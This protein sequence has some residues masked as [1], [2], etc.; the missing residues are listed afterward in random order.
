MPIHIYV[1]AW[2]GEREDYAEEQATSPR[3]EAA[4]APSAA[5]EVCGVPLQQG[6]H[7]PK[8]GGERK[9]TRSAYQLRER[10][11]V[12]LTPR[13]RGNRERIPLEIYEIRRA[14][15]SEVP[16]SFRASCR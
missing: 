9:R 2:A 6:A 11:H 13:T 14:A 8:P 15:V 3:L 10:Q 7:H 12:D 5:P 16:S 4:P 1:Y